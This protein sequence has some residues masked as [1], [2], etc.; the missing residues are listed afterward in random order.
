MLACAGVCASGQSVSVSESKL[1]YLAGTT[2][3][4]VVGSFLIPIFPLPLSYR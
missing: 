2:N 1:K 3:I 4:N